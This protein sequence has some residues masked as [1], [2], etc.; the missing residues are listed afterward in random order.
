[1]KIRVCDVCKTNYPTTKIKYKAKQLELSNDELFNVWRKIEI[2]DD[3]LNKIINKEML[4]NGNGY[5]IA[6]TLYFNKPTYMCSNCGS[7][8]EE[9]TLFCPNCGADMRGSDIENEP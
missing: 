9:P 2:C 5:W 1:M 4:C 6:G 7:N 3:C 8:S